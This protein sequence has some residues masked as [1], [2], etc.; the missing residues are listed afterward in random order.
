VL[1]DDVIEEAK[2]LKQR[3][4]GD[5]IV[6]GSAQLARALFAAGL[7]DELH[8]MVFPLILGSGKTLFDSNGTKALMPLRE[9]KTVGDGNHH[10]HLRAD[11]LTSMIES[12]LFG[13][14]L[15]SPRPPN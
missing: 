9:A 12:R 8:L 11:R 1:G 14:E 15:G 4:D 10:P 3:I 6:H 7:V 13:F 5:I 2:A